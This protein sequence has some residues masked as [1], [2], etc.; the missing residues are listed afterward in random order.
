MSQSLTINRFAGGSDPATRTGPGWIGP[1][2][3]GERASASGLLRRGYAA[4]RDTTAFQEFFTT[5]ASK[6]RNW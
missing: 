6:L 3:C 4:S 1:A 2:S 5:M